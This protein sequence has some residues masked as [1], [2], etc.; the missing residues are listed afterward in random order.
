MD[1]QDSPLIQTFRQVAQQLSVAQQPGSHALRQLEHMCVWLEGQ[2][3]AY[4]QETP[5]ELAALAPVFAATHDCYDLQL[6]AAYRLVD[7]AETGC[8]EA[9]AEA[10]TWAEEGENLLKQLEEEI[11]TAREQES[12]YGGYLC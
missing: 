1:T 10:H 4:G 7:F 8:A 3:V 9:L 5:A 11:L 12:L 6:Q 2:V